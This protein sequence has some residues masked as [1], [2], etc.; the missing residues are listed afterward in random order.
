VKKRSASKTDRELK[1]AL[2]EHQPYKAGASIHGT[3]LRVEYAP[4]GA[5]ARAPETPPGVQGPLTRGH[6]ALNLGHQPVGEKLRARAG[7]V[8]RQDDAL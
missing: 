5:T 4:G 7:R 3:A 2:T 1:A 6:N 8:S